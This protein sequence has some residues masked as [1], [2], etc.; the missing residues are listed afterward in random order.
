[1]HWDVLAY[2]G[3]RA[4]KTLTILWLEIANVH[5]ALSPS[6]PL[7]TTSD[8]HRA[9]RY[10]GASTLKLARFQRNLGFRLLR[11]CASTENR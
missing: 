5:R 8:V 1:M 7:I 3:T 11:G 10:G 6:G 4:P 2:G 9:A